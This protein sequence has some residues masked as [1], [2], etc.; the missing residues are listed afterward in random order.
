MTAYTA[1]QLQMMREALAE[2]P[3]GRYA[4]F[5]RKALAAATLKADVKASETKM[6]WGKGAS[7]GGGKP[8]KSAEATE[9]Q[10]SFITSL[11]KSRVVP[12]ELKATAEG[13]VTK[14]QASA[15]IDALTKCPWLPKEP[16]K[17]ETKASTIAEEGF[18]ILD[19]AYY[20]VKA[21]VSTGRRYASV[22]DTDTM[23]WEYAQG[24]VYKLTEATRLTKE[25]AAKFGH[26]YGV[27]CICSRPL[28]NEA[29]IEAGIGPVCMAK[30]GW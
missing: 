16:K 23:H 21:N 26:L 29:S 22:F 8:K 2:N 7:R 5:Q 10:L 18:Y 15:V 19:G 17:A 4:E 9:K 13:V 20:K 24:M 28:S 12:A 11:L 25:E 30:M 6:T 1:Y 27:C 3:T 14:A